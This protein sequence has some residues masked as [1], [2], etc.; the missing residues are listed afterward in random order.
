MIMC[1]IAVIIFSVNTILLNRTV[2]L[3]RKRLLELE[4]NFICAKSTAEFINKL[5]KNID[6]GLSSE[7][8]Q[9]ISEAGD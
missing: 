1:D 3:M 5:Q 7:A 4:L 8:T 2:Y 6:K 9:G